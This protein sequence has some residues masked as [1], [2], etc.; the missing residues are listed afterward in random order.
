MWGVLY[1]WI[2]EEN[3]PLSTTLSQGLESLIGLKITFIIFIVFLGLALIPITFSVLF[4]NVDVEKKFLRQWP[5]KCAK[6]FLRFASIAYFIASWLKVVALSLVAAFD[7]SANQKA[8]Y[9]A[10]ATAFSLII[11]GN[12]MLLLRR[13]SIFDYLQFKEEQKRVLLPIETKGLYEFMDTDEQYKKALGVIIGFNTLWI[14]LQIGCAI[15]FCVTTDGRAEC[16]LTFLA[17]SDMLFQPFDFYFDPRSIEKHK[18][19]LEP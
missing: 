16:A 13:G 3:L 9:G 14:L 15:I 8:H 6:R 12:F 11:F 17:V 10:A 19:L 4:Y 2:A 1:A 5:D 18:P 7:M